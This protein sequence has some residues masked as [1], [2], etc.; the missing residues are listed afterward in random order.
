VAVTPRAAYPDKGRDGMKI[1]TIRV[2]RALSR[3]LAGRGGRH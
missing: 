3:I 1:I 2:P